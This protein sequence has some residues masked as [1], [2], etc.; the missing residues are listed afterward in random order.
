[1]YTANL[2]WNLGLLDW[3]VAS[4]PDSIVKSL[5]D[6]SERPIG[7]RIFLEDPRARTAHIWAHMPERTEY[8]VK[9]DGKTVDLR[10]I[11]SV[12]QNI[13]GG[14]QLG[15]F[16]QSA[17]EGFLRSAPLAMSMMSVWSF[18]LQRPVA[19]RELRIDDRTNGAVW[20]VRPQSQLPLQ[21]DG[22]N[23]SLAAGNSVGSLLALFREG[24][25]SPQPAYRFLCFFKIIDAWKNHHGPFA[26]TDGLLEKKGRKRDTST[27][28]LHEEM[29]SGKWPAE[30]YKDNLGK[31]FTS[32]IDAMERR[33]EF[34]GTSISQ[35]QRI[36][37]A[38]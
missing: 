33:A 14:L 26:Q 11:P 31:K 5:A 29:L 10:I 27:L 23:V 34:P 30:N 3:L 13:V 24:M 2:P 1:M 32:C 35:E 25:A 15:T 12:D 18:Q 8:H 17:K 9:I 7:V 36:R 20:Q 21:L 38:R 22:L 4:E 37:L 6:T 19:V 28:V 16:A